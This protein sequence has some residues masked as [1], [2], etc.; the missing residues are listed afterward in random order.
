MA[1]TQTST[2]SHPLADA[3][4]PAA[5]ATWGATLGAAWTDANIWPDHPDAQLSRLRGATLALQLDLATVWLFAGGQ[6]WRRLP[7]AAAFV[8][9]V[10][11]LAGGSSG[12]ITGAGAGL[13]IA[14]AWLAR[15]PGV[16]WLARERRG[17]QFTLA[18][19]WLGVTWCFLALVTAGRLPRPDWPAGIGSLAADWGPLGYV[20]LVDGLW[21]AIVVAV[22]QRRVGGV[23]AAAI[24]LAA[25]AWC[26]WADPLSGTCG[27]GIPTAIRW[28]G[29]FSLALVASLEVL[30]RAP[31]A[32][33]PP[34]PRVRGAFASRS[35]LAS[36]SSTQR[37]N[38]C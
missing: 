37:A 31:P 10:A 2:R 21:L 16:W 9:L 3:L 20:L 8:A 30:R 12:Q 29:P 13:P 11:W 1:Q 26:W 27:L 28:S 4:W 35:G 33:G 22:G 6:V 7:V 17:A 14:W 38:N 15:W 32:T 18:E 25:W 34:S 19:C 23:P 24:L 5:L 36:A